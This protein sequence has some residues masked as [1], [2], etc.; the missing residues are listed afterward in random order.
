MEQTFRRALDLELQKVCTFYESKERELRDEVNAVLDDLE[1]FKNDRDSK[2]S[3]FDLLDLHGHGR[4]Q[5]DASRL[6]TSGILKSLHFG[7][8]RRSS[9]MSASAASRRDDHEDDTFDGMSALTRSRTSFDQRNTRDA[10]D[11]EQSVEDLRGSREIY[12]SKRKPSA[13]AEEYDDRT[14]SALFESSVVLK[15]RIISVYVSLC[16][17]KSFIQLNKTG[18]SKALKKFDK[19]LN[20][21]LRTEYLEKS[22]EP[23]WPFRKETMSRLEDSIAKIETAYADVTTKGDVRQARR[24]LRLHLREYVVW[25]RNTVWREM[26]GMERKA[27]A[28]RLGLRPTLLSGTY[29]HSRLQRQGDEGQ[30]PSTTKI[31]TPVGRVYCP[32]WLLNSSNFILLGIIICFLILLFV[33]IMKKP[34]QQ[35]CLAMLVFVSLLWATEVGVV[36]FLSYLYV[37]VLIIIGDTPIRNITTSSVSRRGATHRLRRRSA[38]STIERQGSDIVHLLGDVELGDHAAAGRVYHRGG[39]VQIPNRADPGHLRAQQ[40]RHATADGVADEHA[41]GHG[42]QHVDQ[43]RRRPRVILLHHPTDPTQPVGRLA[44]R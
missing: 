31:N 17:L 13:V 16:E 15:K 28:A 1:T 25:E 11:L 34:E 3:T 38:S 42:G 10:S 27:D 6:S 39:A 22:V 24:E 32:H 14:F 36:T 8:P 2:G 44:L 19:T 30:E 29:D 26:I 41:R 43:Q 20:R 23:A 18:F 4:D 21:N 37:L 35:N 7:R 9:T 40:G 5:G 12:R 33:P